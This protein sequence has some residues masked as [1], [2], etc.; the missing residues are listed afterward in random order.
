MDSPKRPTSRLQILKSTATHELHSL[1]EL[2][3]H[4]HLQN[5]HK[6]VKFGPPDQEIQGFEEGSKFTVAG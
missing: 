6:H 4:H 1:Q 3:R 5:K 2:S